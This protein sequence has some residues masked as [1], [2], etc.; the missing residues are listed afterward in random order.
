MSL[1]DA[2]TFSNRRGLGWKGAAK[3]DVFVAAAEGY[4]EREIPGQ[5]WEPPEGQIWGAHIRL[6]PWA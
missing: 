1:N 3:P 5:G 4:G 6:Q 2:E